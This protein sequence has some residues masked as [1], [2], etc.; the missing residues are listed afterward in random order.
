MLTHTIIPTENCYTFVPHGILYNI[1][2]LHRKKIT[3]TAARAGCAI[4]SR[5]GIKIKRA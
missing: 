1:Y 2:K 5:P 4:T 3:T